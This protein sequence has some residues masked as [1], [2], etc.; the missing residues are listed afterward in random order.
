MGRLE[1]GSA[2]MMGTEAQHFR[3]WLTVAASTTARAVI[4]E[5]PATADHAVRYRLALDVLV[6]PN[7]VVDRLVTAVATDSQVTANPPVFND[8][9]EAVIQQKVNE[10]WTT[11]AKLMYPEVTT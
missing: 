2:L 7:I 1:N 3:N 10:V 9:A 8:A 6:V 11:I 4:T 5:D